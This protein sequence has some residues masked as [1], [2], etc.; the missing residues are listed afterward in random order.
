MEPMGRMGPVSRIRPIAVYLEIRSMPQ[1]VSVFARRPL[2]GWIEDMQHAAAAEDRYRALLAIH[3][4]GPSEIAVQWCRHALKD[5]DPGIRALAVKQLG[6][7]KRIYPSSPNSTAWSEV[8]AE[9]A[10]HLLNDDLDV[11][12][13]AARA[14]GRIDPLQSGPK[15]VLLSLLDD[16]QTQPL[17]VAIVI[18]ALIERDDADAQTM[19]PHLRR[20]ISHDQAEVRENASAAIAKLESSADQM[21]P[22]LIT[23]LEDDEPIVREN[24]AIALGQSRIQS[25]QVQFALQTAESDEDE[26]VANAARDARILLLGR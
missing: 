8:A 4:L 5:A 7:L 18:S 15:D 17:M 20:L 11:R 25:P 9:I 26:G 22:E 3:T 1:P 19:I 2:S 10:I 13:E 14:L 21:I 6:E 16:D 12:F 23:A 24:A